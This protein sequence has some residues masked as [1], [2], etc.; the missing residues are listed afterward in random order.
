MR[1]FYEEKAAILDNVSFIPTTKTKA[2]IMFD[3]RF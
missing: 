1:R 3:E 2:D